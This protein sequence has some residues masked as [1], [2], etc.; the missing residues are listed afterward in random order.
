M[1]QNFQAGD[2]L[3]F[4]IESGYALVRILAIDEAENNEKIWHLTAFNELFLDVETAEAALENP[5]EL[6][7]SLP[8]FAVTQRAFDSTQVAR[9]GNRPLSNDE[10]KR[11][12]DWREN[13]QGEV[14]DRSVRL[15]LG[16]R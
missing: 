12:E 10:I 16:L 9:L 2:N 4:Q 15:M 3:V 1:S 8:H 11:V 13:P 7:L 6:T 5:S 14:S